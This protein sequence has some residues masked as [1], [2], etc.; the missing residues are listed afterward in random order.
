MLFDIVKHH[1]ACGL[2]I[3]NCMHPMCSIGM[4]LQRQ[5]R[6]KPQMLKKCV[7]LH[8]KHAHADELVYFVHARKLDIWECVFVR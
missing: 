6:S 7:Q 1:H 8:A 4:G 2:S 3:A 5:L